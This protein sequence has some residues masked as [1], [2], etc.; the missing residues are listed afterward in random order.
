M[1]AISSF[2]FE[3]FAYDVVGNINREI[4]PIKK[5]Y[6]I[7]VLAGYPKRNCKICDRMFDTL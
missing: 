4:A 7:V 1:A 6:F 5:K 3:I 2:V